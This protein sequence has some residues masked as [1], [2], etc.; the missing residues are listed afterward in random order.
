MALWQLVCFQDQAPR[1][2]RKARA[3]PRPPSLCAMACGQRPRH[4]VSSH[5]LHCGCQPVILSCN[6]LSSSLFSNQHHMLCKST[7]QHTASTDLLVTPV[8]RMLNTLRAPDFILKAFE[9]GSP[10]CLS[11]PSFSFPWLHLCKYGP[12]KTQHCIARYTFQPLQY[13]CLNFPLW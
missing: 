12:P 4:T 5:I 7:C 8:S 2:D 3:G 10:H 13:L 6:Y 1:A 11:L 9:A